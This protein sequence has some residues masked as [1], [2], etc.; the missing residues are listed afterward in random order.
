[1]TRHIVFRI[2]A[3]LIL[4]AAIAGIAFLAYSAGVAQKLPAAAPAAPQTGAPYPY[5]F[6]WWHPFG[7]WGFGCLIPLAFLFL[8]FVAFGSMR[9][10][11]WGPRWGWHHMHRH[12]RWSEEDWKDGVPPMVSEMHRRMHADP[13]WDKAPDEKQK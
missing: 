9:R 11:I 12:G 5:A 7:F 13:N 4:L 10:M 8:L 6:G 3:A 1:M 2:L